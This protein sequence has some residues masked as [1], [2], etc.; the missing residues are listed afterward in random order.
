MRLSAAIF[1]Q[2]FLGLVLVTA[3]CGCKTKQAVTKFKMPAAPLAIGKPI[4]VSVPE[5]KG[6][7]EERT[8][9]GSDTQTATAVAGAFKN[10]GT[11]TFGREPEAQ[12]KAL[13]S[14]A[15]AQC[16]YLVKPTI[17]IW[18]DNPTEWNGEPDEL[19]VELE[20]FD[21]A[22][23][24]SLARASLK[25]KSKLATVLGDKPEDM[26]PGFFEPF[27]AE[28]FGDKDFGQKKKKK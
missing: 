8:Y 26:L 13:G 22:G 14:A 10:Y 21:V 16:V 15:A 6:K 12:E 7:D 27:A 19:E 24:E 3:M 18:E 20:V 9:Q 4:Y 11:V 2:G 1:K 28:L 17:R 5:T 23:K 25:G